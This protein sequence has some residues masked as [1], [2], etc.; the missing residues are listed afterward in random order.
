MANTYSVQPDVEVQIE[1][2]GGDLVIQG[3]PDAEIRARGDDPDVHINDDGQRAEIICMGDCRIR[4]PSGARLRIGAIGSDARITDVT[5]LG[6]NPGSPKNPHAA[7]GYLQ[8]GAVRRTVDEGG[9]VGKFGGCADARVIL[10]DLR[11]ALQV[12]KTA[13]A[14]DFVG[15]E[16]A[17]LSV[18]VADDGNAALLELRIDHP[19]SRRVN[20]QERYQVRRAQLIHEQSALGVVRGP[21]QAHLCAP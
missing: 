15:R 12:V 20:R 21:D 10:I 19:V 13:L 2:I 8:I 18:S 17:G 6:I 4:V 1:T 16:V 14:V 7:T 3:H 11:R 9:E 5:G